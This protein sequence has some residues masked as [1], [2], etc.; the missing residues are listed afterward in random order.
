MMT[1]SL[2]QVSFINNNVF[3]KIELFLSL[4]ISLFVFM[5]REA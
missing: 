2:L 5:A 3:T 1:I 4:I